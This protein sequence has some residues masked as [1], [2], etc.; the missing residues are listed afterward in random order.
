M[1]RDGCVHYSDG[2]GLSAHPLD[3]PQRSLADFLL[4]AKSVTEQQDPYFIPPGGD[5][6][7]CKKY[8]K[9]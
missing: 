3:L 9:R 1:V 4:F 2:G 6:A 8:D 5:V 7:A